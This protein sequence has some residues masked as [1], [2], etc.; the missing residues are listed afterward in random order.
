MPR[1]RHYG[2]DASHSSDHIKAGKFGSLKVIIGGKRFSKKRFLQ[3]N[4]VVTTGRT[5]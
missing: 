1:E 3:I 2:A 4:L 5:V